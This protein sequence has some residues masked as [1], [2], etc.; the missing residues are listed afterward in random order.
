MPFRRMSVRPHYFPF[1]S[2]F[3]DDQ[4]L[5]LTSISTLVFCLSQEIF[6]IVQTKLPTDFRNEVRLIR[7]LLRQAL[8]LLDKYVSDFSRRLISC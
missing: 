1:G 4:L 2:S 6:S 5:R 7:P 3:V 8:G